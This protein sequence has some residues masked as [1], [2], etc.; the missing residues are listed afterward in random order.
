MAGMRPGKCGMARLVDRL[1]VKRGREMVPTAGHNGLHIVLKAFKA[2]LGGQTTAV[3]CL[4]G[5]SDN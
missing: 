3:R 4:Y 2:T 5:Y 1:L